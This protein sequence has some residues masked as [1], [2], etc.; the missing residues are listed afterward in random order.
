MTWCSVTWHG[1]SDLRFPWQVFHPNL[2]FLGVKSWC[3]YSCDWSS[4]LSPVI[5]PFVFPHPPFPQQN[6]L[7]PTLDYNMAHNIGL[8][9]ELVVL[10]RELFK[11]RISISGMESFFKNKA[12]IK[13]CEI[14][15]W[16]NPYS[17]LKEAAAYVNMSPAAKLYQLSY[18]FYSTLPTKPEKLWTDGQE[19][20]PDTWW[21]IR[22]DQFDWIEAWVLIWFV[23]SV[24]RVGLDFC[25]C[26][27]RRVK[28]HFSDHLQL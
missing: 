15:I 16:L 11:K 19:I 27:R 13:S 24:I 17:H 28:D 18:S 10:K 20:A 7:L 21:A 26:S 5:V 12:K 4:T 2:A 6:P 8:A 25:I 23:P 1:V 14:L 3:W 9:S 22:K